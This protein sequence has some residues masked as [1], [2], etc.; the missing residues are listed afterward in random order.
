MPAVTLTV[1]GM[2]LCVIFSSLQSICVSE[3]G[4]MVNYHVIV[5]LQGFFFFFLHMF[6]NKEIGQDNSLAVQKTRTFTQH[7]ML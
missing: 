6:K 7:C 3:L 4:F 1:S 5:Y 2:N